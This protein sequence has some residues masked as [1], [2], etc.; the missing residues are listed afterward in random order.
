MF[1]SKLHRD[2]MK[3]AEAKKKQLQK[4]LVTKKVELQITERRILDRPLVI[5][6]TGSLPQ[7]ATLDKTQ[8]FAMQKL[9]PMAV[10]QGLGGYISR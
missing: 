9:V 10:N 6:N 8:P 7:F 3:A 4:E 2:K 1:F 5:S